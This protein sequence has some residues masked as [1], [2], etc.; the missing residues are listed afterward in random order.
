M[1]ETDARVA[2]I[3]DWL[4]RELRLKVTRIEPASSDASFRR[5][6]RAFCNGGAYVVMDAPP[7]KEDVRPYLK[8]SRLLAS[9]GAPVPHVQETDVARGLLLREDL[10]GARQLERR[11]AGHG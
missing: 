11:E 10:G 9:L 7:E 3:R 4:S 1:L 8:V 5:Y 6:F 2:L